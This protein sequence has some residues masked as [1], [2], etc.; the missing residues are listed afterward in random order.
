[1]GYSAPAG[2][3]TPTW[4]RLAYRSGYTEY[5]L[6]YIHIHI[7]MRIAAATVIDINT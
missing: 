4:K 7:V 3:P 1:M 5:I 2:A 6:T